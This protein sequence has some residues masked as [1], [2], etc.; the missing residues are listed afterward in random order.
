MY[1]TIRTIFSNPAVIMSSRTCHRDGHDWWKQCKQILNRTTSTL[2][3]MRSLMPVPR[4]RVSMTSCAVRLKSAGSNLSGF[5]PSTRANPLPPLRLPE[6]LVQGFPDCRCKFE[7]LRGL[8]PPSCH[9]SCITICDNFFFWRLKYCIVQ[10]FKKKYDRNGL[11]LKELILGV[12][13][14][15]SS[16][17]S[18]L[19]TPT[20]I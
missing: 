2:Y 1:E 17:T 18:P 14:S 3:R 5:A 16:Y 15:F 13:I 8:L 11:A 20:L 4:P 7:Q 9:A 19:H 10:V 12:W 6:V